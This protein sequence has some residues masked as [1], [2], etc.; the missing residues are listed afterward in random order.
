[1]CAVTTPAE[2][3]RRADST[4]GG[5]QVNGL[6]AHPRRARGSL[7]GR[8]PSGEAGERL[9]VAPLGLGHGPRALED[10]LGALVDRDV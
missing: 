1:M 2:R 8:A 4:A 9:R 5:R 6:P 3:R 10:D 7:A